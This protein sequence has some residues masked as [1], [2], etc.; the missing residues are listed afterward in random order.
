[1]TT[2]LIK[3][4]NCYRKVWTAL[5][6]SIPLFPTRTHLSFSIRQLKPGLLKLLN[7]SCET[8]A[9]RI[10]LSGQAI[11]FKMME[12]QSFFS[13]WVVSW[14][15]AKTSMLWENSI[16]NLCLLK[17]VT[18]NVSIVNSYYSRNHRNEMWRIF[19]HQQSK[20]THGKLVVDI[21]YSENA[22]RFS[23]WCCLQMG[24]M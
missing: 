2:T 7:T 4:I 5:E 9:H 14:N 11:A 21:F 12:F 8:V 15:C 1:M 3:D 23:Q 24:S 6:D 20:Y 10:L 13:F 18:Y 22:D 16:S 19:I 17:K